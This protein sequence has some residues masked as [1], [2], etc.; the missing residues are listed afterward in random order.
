MAK[1]LEEQ[2]IHGHALS[3]LGLLRGYKT[4][5]T[6]LQVMQVVDRVDYIMSATQKVYRDKRNKQREEK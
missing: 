3:V 4:D 2:D 1:K 5:L 6:P